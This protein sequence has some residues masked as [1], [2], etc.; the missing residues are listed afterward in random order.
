MLEQMFDAIVFKK[1]MNDHVLKG[2]L[3][4]EFATLVQN[5]A[6][7]EDDWCIDHLLAINIL[8]VI[9]YLAYGDKFGLLVT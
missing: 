4:T 1:N 8:P 7:I 6:R 9:L 5:L 3:L 2:D